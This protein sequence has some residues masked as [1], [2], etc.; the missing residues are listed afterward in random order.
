[1]AREGMSSLID[2]LRIMTN[3]EATSHT[4]GGTSIYSNDDLEGA[5]DR[6]RTR[7]LDV[8]L[9]SPGEFVNGNWEYYDYTIPGNLKWL[10]RDTSG[11]RAW[12][13]KDNAGSALSP[14]SINYNAGVVS[15]ASDQGGSAVYLDCRSYDIYAAAADIWDERA[16]LESDKVTFTTGRTRVELSERVKQYREQAARY[17]AKSTT[18]AG[19]SYI[20]LTR[21]DEY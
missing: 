18:G 13:L 10:E 8:T 2:Q 15:F 14:D 7:L 12:Y 6:Y 20:R 11:T 4:L 17:R 9:L 21:S 3:V 16:A 1:M 5:L 19:V